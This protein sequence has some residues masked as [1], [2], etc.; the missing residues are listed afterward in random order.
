MNRAESD[1]FMC[2]STGN[3]RQLRRVSPATV[4]L[5][6]LLGVACAK[7]TVRAQGPGPRS[8]RG[9]LSATAAKTTALQMPLMRVARVGATPASRV[10]EDADKLEDSNAKR[11][12]RAMQV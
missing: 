12:R 6:M 11:A 1:T 3:A 4:A 2:S 5:M 7:G 9:A 8:S 10:G